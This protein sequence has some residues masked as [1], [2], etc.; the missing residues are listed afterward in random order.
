MNKRTGYQCVNLYK[1]GHMTTHLVH[2]LVAEAF[3]PNPKNKP[4]VNHING[5]KH[6]SSLETD[7]RE[8]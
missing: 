6:D 5:D 3:I 2:R 8:G 4:E 1:D 7:A